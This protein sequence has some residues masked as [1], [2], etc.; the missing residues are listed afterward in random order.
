MNV[1]LAIFHLLDGFWSNL[2]LRVSTASCPLPLRSVHYNLYMKL[3][4]N[5][6]SFL[7]IGFLHIIDFMK[8][9]N[10]Y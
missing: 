9:Y 3:K 8:I 6:A 7:Q 4:W 10:L 5:F 2:V 1:G